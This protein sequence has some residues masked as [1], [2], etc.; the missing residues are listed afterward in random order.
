MDQKTAQDAQTACFVLLPGAWSGPWGWEPVR[1]RLADHGHDV[2]VVTFSGLNDGQDAAEVGLQTHVQDVISLIKKANLHDVHIVGHSYSGLVAGMVTDQM[3]DRIRHTTYVEGFV[4]A[5]GAS[6][7]DAFPEE[8]RE[9]ELADI[10]AHDGCWPAP[11]VE[12]VREDPGLSAEMAEWIASR[13]APHPGRTVTEQVTLSMPV[14]GQ[15]STCIGSTTHSEGLGSLRD[16]PTWRFVPL[17][18]GHWP[19]FSMPRQLTEV[20]D[21][22]ART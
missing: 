13:L 12:D 10:K 16:A 18:G 2:H 1:K 19:M 21:V 14:R 5:D 7:L 9:Q 15:A 6:L 8:Q 11:G 17:D 3:P 20:L 4:P 22:T